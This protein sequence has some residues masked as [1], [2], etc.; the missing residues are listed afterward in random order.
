MTGESN[1]AK[2]RPDPHE[3]LPLAAE[4]IVLSAADSLAFAAML[5]HPP[6]PSAHLRRA[7]RSHRAL[8]GEAP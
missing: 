8:I 7:A 5:L 1:E 3:P 6:E 4:T 2:Q